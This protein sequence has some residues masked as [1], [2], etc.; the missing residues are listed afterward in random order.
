MPGHKHT[1][2][3][4]K[5]CKQYVGSIT[6]RGTNKYLAQLPPSMGRKSKMF[7]SL[8]EAQNWL[9]QGE[10][11]LGSDL[12]LEATTE[13]CRPMCVAEAV[14][15][16]LESAV[17]KESV[18]KAY[19]WIAE[20]HVL[21]TMGSN[22]LS[23]L[24]PEDIDRVMR[25]VP[26][27]STTGKVGRVLSGLCRWAE[28]NG[29]IQTNP[30]TRSSASRLCK[31]AE[32]QVEPRANAEN[33]WTADQVR[34]FIQGEEHPMYRSLWSLMAVTG[35]RRGEALGIQVSGV[36]EQYAWIEKNV[37]VVRGETV[38][39]PLPKSWQRRKAYVKDRSSIATLGGPWLFGGSQPLMPEN[40]TLRFNRLA[41]KLGLPDLGGPHGLRRTF[42]T[43]ADHAGI[44]E[45]VV[46][47]A[48]GHA[49]NMTQR[50][51]KVSEA[52]LINL[53]SAMEALILG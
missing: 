50:Y 5:D 42:A 2:A 29:H 14:E 35:V 16:W 43:L 32:L 22:Q 31:L 10:V 53:A 38:V 49:P 33:T 45:R 7:S 12:G 4:S 25:S 9:A 6:Q 17:L 13:G 18:R 23:T 44:R 8:L 34:T 51:Q 37:T 24:R 48:L 46:Q 1:S 36:T 39:E 40:V 41:Q 52:E 47:Q 15:A 27:N 30:Y 3:C 19:R 28:A 11:S 26:L 20:R 21:P